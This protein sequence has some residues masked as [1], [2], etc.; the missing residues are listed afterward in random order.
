M[1][2]GNKEKRRTVLKHFGAVGVSSVL[3]TTGSAATDTND[4]D[5]VPEP[6]ARRFALARVKHNS[7]KRAFSAFKSAELGQPELFYLSQGGE[8][9]PGAWVYPIEDGGSEVGHVAAG[10]QRWLPRVIKTS[11]GPAPQHRVERL[12]TVAQAN[13]PRF[14]YDHP[15]VFGVEIEANAADGT[16]QFVDLQTGKV[17]GIDHDEVYQAKSAAKRDASDTDPTELET[18]VSS[19]EPTSSEEIS[20]VPNWDGRKCGDDWVGCTPTASA[21]CI[22]F[23]EYV[24]DECDLM[25]T[26][27]D[28]MGTNSDGETW[29][30]LPWPKSD[31]VT[32]ISDYGSYSGSNTYYGRRSEIKSQID[33]GNPCIVSYFGDKGS[34]ASTEDNG[35]SAMPSKIPD[36]PVGHSETG[37]GYEDD[38][39][40]LYVSTHDTYGN[41]NELVLTSVT[42]AYLA[43][44]IEP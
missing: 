38:D 36:M 1:S 22:G 40:D 29:P 28:N 14:L 15:L 17:S 8:Y 7:Q 3:L 20:G 37:W 23:H 41:T 5:G 32:G 27:N 25:W 16:S 24:S 11:T 4:S 43:Q 21:M 18:S 13:E 19:F 12:K 44:S 30:R 26:L 33:S 35:D 42:D 9:V 34:A 31:F 10:A 2:N 6:V 39:G